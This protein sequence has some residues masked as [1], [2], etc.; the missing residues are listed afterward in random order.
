MKE[1][2]WVFEAD[3]FD[4]L[5]QDEDRVWRT[6]ADFRFA[7]PVRRGR[8]GIE[9]DLR[10]A[11][12]P[13]PDAAALLAASAA[14]TDGA[15]FEPWCVEVRDPYGALLGTAVGVFDPAGSLVHVDELVV[16]RLQR[17][18]GVGDRLLEEIV[19]LSRTRDA[20][21][22]RLHTW[23]DDWMRSWYERRGFVVDAELPR[24]QRGRDM[25]QMTRR[26]TA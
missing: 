10:V 25:V 5:R 18:Q 20:T 17:R 19:L 1:F 16:D 24:W 2:R 26:L 14:V 8:G 4:V 3:G 6:L 21:E 15:A 7:A 9:V 11:S 23:A 12:H 22:V 13:S